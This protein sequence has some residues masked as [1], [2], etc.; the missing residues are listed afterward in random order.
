MTRS[1]AKG[2]K[3]NKPRY[4]GIWRR[5]DVV[6]VSMYFVSLVFGLSWEPRVH[7]TQ[8]VFKTKWEKVFHRRVIGLRYASPKIV[9]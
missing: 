9:T 1:M 6:S 2:P 3:L 5:T 7:S 4:P 8:G